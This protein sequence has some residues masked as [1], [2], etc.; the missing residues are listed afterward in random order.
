MQIQ[1]HGGPNDGLKIE[2]SDMSKFLTHPIKR[3][4]LRVILLLPM[5]DDIEKIIRG[6]LTKDHNFKALSF[7]ERHSLPDGTF[8]FRYATDLD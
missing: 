6:E 7:Y 4:K 5:P 2:H 8:E 1:F 3:D